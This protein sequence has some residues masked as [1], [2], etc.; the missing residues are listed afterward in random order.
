MLDETKQK[1]RFLEEKNRRLESKITCLNTLVDE[2]KQK[3]QLNASY[4]DIL[5]VNNNLLTIIF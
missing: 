1:I 4:S 3:Y 2:L 5:R